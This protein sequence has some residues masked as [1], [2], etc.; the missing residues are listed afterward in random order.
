MQGLHF[1]YPMVASK[2]MARPLQVV[3]I[4]PIS[5]LGGMDLRGSWAVV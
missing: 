2:N 3:T 1:Q 5:A 4:T